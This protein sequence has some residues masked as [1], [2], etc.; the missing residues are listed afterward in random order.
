M[1][2]LKGCIL[3]YVC[4]LKIK[5]V[6]FFNLIKIWDFVCEDLCLMVEYINIFNINE[7]KKVDFYFFM[8]FIMILF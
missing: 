8:I 5:F 3:I 6:F 7:Y 2:V 1:D 4:F